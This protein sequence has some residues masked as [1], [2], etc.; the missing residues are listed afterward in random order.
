MDIIDYS[1]LNDLTF[2]D[3]QDPGDCTSIK[4]HNIKLSSI[5]IDSSCIF[6]ERLRPYN[7]NKPGINYCIVAFEDVRLGTN[8]NT[9]ASWMLFC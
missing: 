8:N 9:D 6:M 4:M 5:T 3:T 2:R 1:I 7:G